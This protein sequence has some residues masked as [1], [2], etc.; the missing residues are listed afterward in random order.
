MAGQLLN[1][2]PILAIRDGEVEPIKRVRGNQ[3][4]FMEFV[5]QFRE[6]SADGAGLR[7]GIAHADAP[8]RAQALVEMVQRERPQAQVEIV[9]TLGAVVGTHAGPGHSRVLLVRRRGGTHGSPT[10]PLL[11][12]SGVEDVGC[13]LPGG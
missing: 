7:V 1:I 13:G 9:T 6:H 4:A 11:H 5:S 3:K 2:K 12:L 8:E 10:S